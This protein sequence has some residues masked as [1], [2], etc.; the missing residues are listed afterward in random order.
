MDQLEKRNQLV[1]KINTLKENTRNV[2]FMKR[3][4][5]K[6]EI[7]ELGEEFRKI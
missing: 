1:N 6:N 3:L 2:D 7:I 5:L 4:Q